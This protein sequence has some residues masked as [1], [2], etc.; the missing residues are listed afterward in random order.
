MDNIE[1]WN[2]RYLNGGN[3]GYG[4]YEDQV[5]IKLNAIFKHIKDIKSI[6]D[7]GCGDFHFS[8]MVID[9]YKCPYLGIDQSSVVIEKNSNFPYTFKISETIDMPTELVMC[10]DVLF[11]ITDEDRYQKTLNNLKESYTKY[12]VISAFDRN[13]PNPDNPQIVIR[14]L[15]ETIGK[16]IYKELL[17]PDGAYLYIFKK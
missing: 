14:K 10:I 7:L 2:Q 17:E 13:A 15:D 16:L 5:Q 8:Q 1:Y 12:L 11:H 3:S 4:S 6:T 9:H